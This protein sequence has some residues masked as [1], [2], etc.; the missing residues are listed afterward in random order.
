MT[1]TIASL[2]PPVRRLLP[3]IP[4]KTVFAQGKGRIILGLCDTVSARILDISLG[5]MR[6]FVRAGAGMGRAGVTGSDAVAVMFP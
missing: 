2:R 6:N 4:I 5:P 3:T 1:T